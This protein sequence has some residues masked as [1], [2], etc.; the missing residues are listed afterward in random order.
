M[1]SYKAILNLQPYGA[2]LVVTICD[3]VHRSA[4]RLLKKDE[5]YEEPFCACGL[6]Y[7][8]DVNSYHIWIQ[9]GIDYD[10][11]VPHEVYHLI[12]QMSQDLGLKEEEACAYMMGYVSKKIF[13]IIRK[14]ELNKDL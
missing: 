3:D 14:Q 2:K 1:K 11:Y 9:R 10:L 5:V 6:F 13:T 4:V 8:E 12:S 7:K